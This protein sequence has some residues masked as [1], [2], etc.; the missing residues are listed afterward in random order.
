MKREIERKG[1]ALTNQELKGALGG[2]NPPR[3]P[4]TTEAASRP[5]L[6]LWSSRPVAR[7][8]CL[9]FAET[10][11]TPPR[12]GIQVSG[13]Q[14]RWMGRRLVETLEKSTLKGELYETKE[15]ESQERNRAKAHRP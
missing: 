4:A 1:R 7:R 10:H 12:P 9:R 5:T 15:T 8:S 13:R 11:R 14:W 3:L 2:V 6:V